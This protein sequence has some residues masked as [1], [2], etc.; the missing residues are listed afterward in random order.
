MTKKKNTSRSISKL[1]PGSSNKSKNKSFK[2]FWR[3]REMK[4]LV[5]KPTKPTLGITW[6]RSKLR[7][8]GNCLENPLNQAVQQSPT[9]GTNNLQHQVAEVVLGHHNRL[10]VL[11]LLP[12][13]SRVLGHRTMETRNRRV[14]HL[15]IGR[16]IHDTCKHFYVLL[17]I[18]E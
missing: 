8:L 3:N 9:C 12:G 10:P 13:T 6:K 5:F 15:H 11:P 18:S 2:L 1:N 14:E 16:V 4:L 7:K 17:E